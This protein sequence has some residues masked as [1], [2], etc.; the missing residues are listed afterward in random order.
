MEFDEQPILRRVCSL[1]S[2]D[3]SAKGVSFVVFLCYKVLD[4]CGGGVLQWC[5]KGDKENEQ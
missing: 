3:I 4:K 2:K 5:R 1:F